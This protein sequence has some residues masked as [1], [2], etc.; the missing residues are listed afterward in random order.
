MY[1]GVFVHAQVLAQI[2]DQRS[3][4]DF[5]WPAWIVTVVVVSLLGFWTGRTGFRERHHLIVEV[6][7]VM[8]LLIFSIV[9]FWLFGIIFPFISALVAFLGSAAGGH[10]GRYAVSQFETR[11]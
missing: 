6:A 5:G 3:V 9:A 10:F 2:L 11:S 7:S 1:P 4:R 8:A